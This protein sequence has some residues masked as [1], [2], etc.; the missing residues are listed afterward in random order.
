MN[1]MTIELNS[2]LSVLDTKSPA[3]KGEWLHLVNPQSGQPMFA[4]DE[5]T[6]PMR[7]K[8]LGSNSDKFA[9]IKLAQTRKQQN[10]AT[11]KLS[12]SEQIKKSTLEVA[13]MFAKM[14]IETENLTEDAK[15]LTQDDLINVYSNHQAICKQ[16]GE[17]IALDAN[18]TQS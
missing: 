5:E 7:I 1:I 17:F 14:T 12:D 18:F 15:V 10:R 11:A 9:K 2:K 4:D 16:V 13:T 8:V 6:K 3:E